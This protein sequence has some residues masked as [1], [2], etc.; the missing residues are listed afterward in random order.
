[1]AEWQYDSKKQGLAT[2]FFD[3]EIETLRLLWSKSG[4]FLTSRQVWQHVSEKMSISRASIINSLN[5]MVKMGVLD[6]NEVT[7]KGGHR[8]L[9]SA[10]KG[11]GELRERIADELSHSI[12]K[13][14]G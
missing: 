10:A 3:Y 12:K 9:Y 4:E 6:Y 11:E 1:M 5:R 8:G 14:I 13:N 2:V 7:G